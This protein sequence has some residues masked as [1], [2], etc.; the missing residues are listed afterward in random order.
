MNIQQLQYF[1]TVAKY[2]NFS[3]AS[4]ELYVTQPAISRQIALLEEEWKCKLFIRQ[5]KSLQ[6]SPQG[7]I[8]LPYA[9]QILNDINS[10]HQRI[11]E[12]NNQIT[13]FHLGYPN[14]TALNYLSKQLDYLNIHY[15]N[16]HVEIVLAPT[17]LNTIKQLEQGKLDAVITSQS[18]LKDSDMIQ[19]NVIAKGKLAIVIS[20]NHPLAKKKKITF[21]DIKDNQLLIH[22]LEKESNSYQTLINE[23]MNHNIPLDHISTI[24]ATDEIF[25]ECAI[26]GA[27]GLMPS[28]FID[29][30]IGSLKVK[31]ISDCADLFGVIFIIRKN[32]TNPILTELMNQL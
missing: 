27:V 3:K 16:T 19:G 32:E 6:L 21:N 8:Y 22:Q 31:D 1:V 26:N 30:R 4:A 10:L 20:P 2:L 7:I 23:C 9:Q 11:E 12:E 5:H 24:K 18:F 28:C 14:L 17:N 25:M 13:T 29:G 15:P